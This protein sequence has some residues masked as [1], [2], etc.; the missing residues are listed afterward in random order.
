MDRIL[1]ALPITQEWQSVTIKRPAL[2][3]L[4]KL[5]LIGM[6]DRIID[7][8]WV[9]ES[10]QVTQVDPPR[11]PV[12]WIVAAEWIDREQADHLPVLPN[13]DAVLQGFQED[14]IVLWQPLD[15]G[16]WN[17]RPSARIKVLSVTSLTRTG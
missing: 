15:E 12:V 13:F 1:R 4:E 9:H 7:A 5:D 8:I 3:L 17:L 16:K 6:N 2:V 14:Q 11:V 10:C